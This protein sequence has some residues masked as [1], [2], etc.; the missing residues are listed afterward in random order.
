MAEVDILIGKDYAPLLVDEST[1]RAAVDADSCPSV[2]FT[3]LGC[4]LYGGMSNTYENSANR[5]LSINHID[6]REEN[7]VQTFF[8]GDIL[9]VKPTSMCVCSDNEIL[10][11]RFIKHMEETTQV[12]LD[13]RVCVR[14]PW[15]SG[16]PDKLPNNYVRARDQLF[17][18]EDQLL[19]NGKLEEYNSEVEKSVERGVVKKLTHDESACA[20]KASA[21][22]LNHR[23]IERPDKVSS[24]LRIVFDSASPYKGICLN[25]ALEKG[26]V[27]TNSLFKCLL[28]WR[29]D[30]VAITGD[31]EKMFNQVAMIED[32]QKY[33]RFLWRNGKKSEPIIVYQWLRVLFGDKPSPDIASFAL[34]F[35]A[36]RVKF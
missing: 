2:A 6:R 18:R 12:D 4:Y 17:K 9:G 14:M 13:G 11:S 15:K 25:D 35:L 1:L 27:Y 34:R 10:E 3:R 22:Y 8:Y 23:I 29:E 32:D 33:H 16:F 31:I 21:W 24:K 19:R 7:E 30:Y 20:D 28:K 26:P 5:I 36:E